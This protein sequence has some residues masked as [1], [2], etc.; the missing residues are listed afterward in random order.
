MFREFC[1]E[2]TVIVPYKAQSAATLISLGADKILM[3]KKAEL[4]PID[5]TLVKMSAAESGGSQQEISIEDVNSFLSFIREKGHISDQA[6]L[7]QVICMLANQL[8]PLTLGNV[9]RT[10]SHIRLVA[11]KMLASR[12]EKLEEAKINSIIETL[13]EKIYSHG[14]AIGRKEAVEIGL[15]VE[16]PDENL[17]TIIWQLFLEYEQLLKLNEPIDPLVALTG[18]E[19]VHLP[20]TPMAV[21]E[22]ENILHA[23]KA[24]IDLKKIRQIPPNAQINLNVNLNLPANIRPEDIPQ[25]AQQIL[26][27]MVTQ[28]SQGLPKL[29]QQEIV[30]QSPEVGLNVRA[31]G[32][33]WLKY[34]NEDLT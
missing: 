24:Q 16:L 21:L 7:S 2:L 34:T 19:E 15:P 18:Q 29:V 1:D 26:Q 22:S 25:Q 31:Y 12:K 33:K 6:A 10:N 5:P 23:L 11:R 30:R 4:G 3:G 9:N 14:H 13:T 17:E 8:T 27:Q 28:V 20:D 32:G